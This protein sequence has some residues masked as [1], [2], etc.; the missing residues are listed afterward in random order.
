MQRNRGFTLIELMI[1]VAI[2]A[3]LAAVGY[4]SY[5]N[6]V[7]KG[8]RSAGQQFLS[9]IAQRQEQYLLD[10]RQYAT[11]LAASATGLGMTAPAA[12]KYTVANDFADGVNN[13]ATPPAFAICAEPLAGSPVAQRADGRLCINNLGQRWRE[14]AGGNGTFDAGECAWDNTSCRIAGEQG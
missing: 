12:L 7:A 3:I 9:D 4:P 5:R 14:P 11:T 1:V 13:A 2:V 8:Q 10:R 6:H